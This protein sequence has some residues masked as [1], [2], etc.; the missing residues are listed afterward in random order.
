MNPTAGSYAVR[1]HGDLARA[2]AVALPRRDP[3]LG[4]HEQ[5]RARLSHTISLYL[6]IELEVQLE[7]LDV[8]LE[9][10][11]AHGPDQVVAVDGLALLLHALVAGPA[12][13]GITH[14]C[15]RTRAAHHVPAFVLEGAGDAGPPDGH[16]AQPSAASPLAGLHV[17]ALVI[18][19]W[20]EEGAPGPR[21]ANPQ[22]QHAAR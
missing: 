12:A 1:H 6:L 15:A 19:R 18:L 3:C 10:E 11:R 21:S 7:G 16:Q 2:E 5:I 4:L 13:P 14:E 9:A 22:E 20:R 8:V 17:L